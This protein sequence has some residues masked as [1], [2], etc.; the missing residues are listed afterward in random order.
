[1]AMT[2][3]MSTEKTKT[4]KQRLLMSLIR[5]CPMGSV[6]GLDSFMGFLGNPQFEVTQISEAT[7]KRRERTSR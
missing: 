2:V 6:A 4:E 7:Q 3:K 1:M 5:F